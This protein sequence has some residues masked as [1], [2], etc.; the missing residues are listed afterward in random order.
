MIP[1]L[2]G[3]FPD[4]S[5]SSA[6]VIGAKSGSPPGGVGVGVGGEVGAGVPAGDGDGVGH[7]VGAGVPAG[8][9]C[10]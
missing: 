10:R 7:D 4:E 2:V 3:E 9:S 5:V 8:Q 1:T 6:T